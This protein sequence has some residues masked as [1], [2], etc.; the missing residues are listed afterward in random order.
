MDRNWAD[1]LNEINQEHFAR[2]MARF[3]DRVKR[4]PED[5]QRALKRFGTQVAAGVP[6]KFIPDIEADILE[7]DDIE[8]SRQRRNGERRKK[9]REQDPLDELIIT[10][11]SKLPLANSEEIWRAVVSA[12]EKDTADN[13]LGLDEQEIANPRIVVHPLNENHGRAGK[14]IVSKSSFPAIL[15][16]LKAKSGDPAK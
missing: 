9:K 1:K 8:R 3:E 2:E 5:L 6:L 15:S 11:R 16:R 14:R 13:R 12:I 7:I 4:N 10:L